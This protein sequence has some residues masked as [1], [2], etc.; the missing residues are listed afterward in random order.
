MRMITWWL[1]KQVVVLNIKWQQWGTRKSNWLHHVKERIRERMLNCKWCRRWA[2]PSDNL[3]LFQTWT[4][5]QKCGLQWRDKKNGLRWP[6][7]GCYDGCA[8]WHA[9]TRS[10]MNTYEEQQEW[11]RLP[12]RS[13]RED[14]YGTC[15][16]WGEMANTYWRKFWGQIYQGKRRED[17]RKPDGKTHVNEIWKVLDWER[18]R[19]RTGRCGE[20][21]SS[22]IPATLLDG[23]SQRKKWQQ[24]DAFYDNTKPYMPPVHHVILDLS[25]ALPYLCTYN[26]I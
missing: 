6:R 12:K 5:G 7:W 23:K 1:T 18:A 22:V 13:P 8:E 25:K 3:I 11:C 14:W 15:M 16:W 21:R 24:F 19:R 9:K 20:E 26:G 17:D 4:E 2:C 10:G